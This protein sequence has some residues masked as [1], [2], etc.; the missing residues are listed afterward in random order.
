[1]LHDM[2]CIL[3]IGIEGSLPAEPADS[4][5]KLAL[6]GPFG[7]PMSELRKNSL[8]TQYTA[9][10]MTIVGSTLLMDKTRI[11]MRPHPILTVNSDQD[12]IAWDA[13][14]LVYLYRQLGIASR[15]G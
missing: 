9:Y 11:G 14:T 2:Q 1:M 7:E 15:A 4:E 5:W 8:E 6:A 10:Y 13:V 3:R 12:E